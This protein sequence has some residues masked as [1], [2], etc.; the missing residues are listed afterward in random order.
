MALIRTRVSIVSLL[1]D[2]SL[3]LETQWTALVPLCSSPGA[4]HILNTCRARN[5]FI[6]NAM[7]SKMIPTPNLKDVRI[8]DF[9]KSSLRVD[10]SYFRFESV[11]TQSC[12][13]LL[14]PVDCSPSGSSVHGILQVRILEWVAIPF[15]MRYSWPRDGTQVSCI[16]GR[17][18][19]I[20]AIRE[21]WK[22]IKSL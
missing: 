16:A 10:A 14:P 17:F 4:C 3:F 21:A 7:V 18:F 6:I 5:W 19:T 15:S 11:V 22:T 1:G 8:A 12:P 9:S 20:W 2:V 13:S